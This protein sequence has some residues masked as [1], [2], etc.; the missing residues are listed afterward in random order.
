MIDA[1]VVSICCYLLDILIGSIILYLLIWIDPKEPS[2]TFARQVT[3]LSL[4]AI[5]FASIVY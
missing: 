5:T 1:C 3:S 4:I 2:Q